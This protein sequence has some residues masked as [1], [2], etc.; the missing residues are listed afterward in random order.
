MIKVI[1]ITGRSLDQGVSKEYGKFSKAYVEKVAVCELD[2]EDMKTLGI[3]PGQ[4]VKV[5][6][7]YGEVVVKA[8]ESTQAP[9]KGIAFIPYGPWAS[10]VMPST[11]ES[12]GMPSLK[13]IEATIEPALDQEILDPKKLIKM[14]VGREP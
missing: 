7:K 9:H 12:T 3:N 4:N 14:I 10:S 5:K 1:L 8:V 6:T 13:G 11:T 2:V